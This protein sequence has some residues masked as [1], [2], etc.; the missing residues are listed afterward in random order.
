MGLFLRNSKREELRRIPLFASLSR[1][2]LD[3]LTR[4]A[5]FVDVP[6]CTE[7]I[8]EGENGHEF[9]AIADGEVEISHAGE[10]IATEQAGDVFGEIS[11][12]H[13]VPRTATVTTTVPSRLVVL[14]EQ[15][16]RSLL[17]HSFV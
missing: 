7:L 11:L 15:A 12:L 6:A 1:Q 9:F 5:D 17:A 10:W 8:R 4:T 3:L 2:Q 13:G 16:F 14:N